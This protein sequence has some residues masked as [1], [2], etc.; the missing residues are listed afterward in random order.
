MK[1]KRKEKQK[2]KKEMGGK[3]ANLSFNQTCHS[4][5]TTF[6]LRFSL[7]GL[8]LFVFDFI[9]SICL[10][11][12]LPLLFAFRFVLPTEFEKLFLEKAARQKRIRPWSRCPEC[13]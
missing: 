7:L 10:K 2:R 5:Q 13:G 9:G 8:N 12:H 6:E 11:S 3:T 4:V 1:K